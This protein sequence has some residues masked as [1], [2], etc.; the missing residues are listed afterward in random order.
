MRRRQQRASRVSTALSRIALAWQQVRAT[1]S[2]NQKKS[3][4]SALLREVGDD[5]LSR[6]VS[7][8]CGD[9]PQ[10]KIGVGYSA[11]YTALRACEPATEPQWT[12]AQIDARFT[13]IQGIAGKG[14]KARRAAAL[15]EL[16]RGATDA[17]QRFLTGLLTGEL[18]QGAL[19]GVVA[20]AIA[21]AS[22][23][24]PAVVR[25]AAM[26][27][28]SLAEVA[29]AAR[30]GGETALRAF[31]M[32]VF[33]PLQ[34]MLAQTAESPDAA[35]ELLGQAIVDHKLDGARIQVHRDG[36]R[37][38]VYTRALH[39]ATGS[40]PEVVHFARSL[41]ET[42]FILDGEVIAFRDD[43]RPHPFQTTMRRFGRSKKDEMAALQAEL[44]LTPV[45]FDVL[46]VGARELIDAPT[47]ERLAALDALVP[48]AN[49]MP[50]LLTS[51]AEAAAA[52]YEDAIDAGH[53]GIMAKDPAAPYAAGSR[54]KAWLK[55]KPAH[56]LDLVVI[57]V[58]WG[59]GRR[60]G[61]LS[62]LHLAAY[63]PDS[64]GF[65]MLGKTFK[66]MTDEL[67]RWQTNELLALEVSRTDWTVTVRPELVV[68]I[69]FNDVQRSPRYPGGVALRFARVK[70]YRPDKKP[71]E[72]DTIDTVRALLPTGS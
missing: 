7:W 70:Q 21:L 55:I 25:R 36:D 14:S 10:G 50:R 20:D 33:T 62:N 37:V 34:P 16:L 1:R 6:T 53:E 30:T 54:G 66:G 40:V 39:T 47:T 69:A 17:E 38:V 60:T 59:S 61:W 44:P 4:L 27:S 48:A 52:F 57:A 28:G 11:A 45:F 26:L 43:G 12:S 8:L 41:P 15:E 24:E 3:V 9:L 19:A 46:L 51:D 35:I 65:V 2:R 67:L 42:R 23:I 22:D 5:E 56:T 32:R 63:D 31:R 58:D 72:A 13:A 64:E 29:L 18:R 68:E 49:R 71:H